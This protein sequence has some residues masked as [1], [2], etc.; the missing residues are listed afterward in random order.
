MLCSYTMLSRSLAYVLARAIY[1]RA[2]AAQS[3]LLLVF[4]LIVDTQYF[5]SVISY[6]SSSI[7]LHRIVCRVY[8]SPLATTIMTMNTTVTTPIILGFSLPRIT[9]RLTL[10]A[11]SHRQPWH[12]PGRRLGH[13]PRLLFHFLEAFQLLQLLL[14]LPRRLP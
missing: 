1:V 3:V 14:L 12:L 7:I 9:I 6:H 5:S 2:A 8:H 13:R 11:S 10:P 4:Q